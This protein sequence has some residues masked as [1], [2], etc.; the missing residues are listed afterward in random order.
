MARCGKKSRPAYTKVIF[1]QNLV[2]GKYAPVSFFNYLSPMQKISLLPVL[3]AILAA[4]CSPATKL[5]SSVKIA[6]LSYN[7]HI[8]NPPT[9]PRGFI[10]LDTIAAT[11][12]SSGAELIALQELDS[13]TR[14]SNGVYQLKVLAEKLN[15]HYHFEKT[16]SHDG[17]SYGIGILSK[18]PL[19]EITAYNLPQIDGI[20]SEPRKMLLAKVM[21]QN[22][23]IF[24]GC[25]HVDFTKQV[26]PA[27]MKELVRILNTLPDLPIIVG[28]DFNATSDSEG[29]KLM[30]GQYHNASIR[31]EFTIPVLHPTKKI[32][33]IFYKG[34][35]FMQDSVMKSHNY[36]S[37]HLPVWAEFKR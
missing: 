18:Y 21:I 30:L 37:D 15:M 3:F 20:K 1:L 5:N 34:L 17:G 8:G 27:Q 29:M 28:G 2:Q 33:Y 10:D 4:G 19:Q 23:P 9:K 25:T 32:D 35:S 36:G 14:R 22:K 31:N 24:F 7:I 12:R 6:V 11:I 26:N 13:I 16:I